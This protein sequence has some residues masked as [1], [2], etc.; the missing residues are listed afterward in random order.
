MKTDIYTLA[1]EVKNPLAVARGYLEMM[2]KDNFSKYK[3]IIQNEI[4]S[5]LE[6]LDNYLEYNKLI[7]SKEE[8]DLNVLLL[9]IKKSMKEYL[10]KKNINLKITMMDDDIYLDADYHKLRQVFLNIIKNSMEAH[11]KNIL[12]SYDI[13]FNKVKIKIENDGDNID[14]DTINKIGNNYSNKVLGNGIGTTLAKKII[15]LHNG[16]IKYSNNTDKGVTVIISLSLN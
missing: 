13:M 9:D 5:S 4:N 11:A 3:E 16:S 2:D 12:I 7:I 10:K 15:E 6:I 1:H 8:I 14:Y